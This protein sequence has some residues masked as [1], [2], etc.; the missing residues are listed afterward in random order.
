MKT[1]RYIAFLTLAALTVLT[2]LVWRA[3]NGPT[4]GGVIRDSGERPLVAAPE[5]RGAGDAQKLM[6]AYNSRFQLTLTSSPVI[7]VAPSSFYPKAIPQTPAEFKPP[8]N[9]RSAGPWLTDWNRSPV[10]ANYLAFGYTAL[11]NGRL[12]L[13]GYFYD[14]SKPDTIGAQLISKL[15]FGENSEVGARSVADQFAA[16]ILKLFGGKTLAG[17]KIWFTSK[18]GPNK[19]IWSM[20]WDGTNQKQFTSYQSICTMPTVS[21]DGSKVAFTQLSNRGPLI[22]VHAAESGRRLPFINPDASTNATPEFTP[23]GSR[24]LFSSTLAGGFA[25]LYSANIDGSDLRRITSFRAIEVE[26]KVNPKTGKTVLYVSDRAGAGRPQIWMMSIEGTDQQMISAGDGEAVNPA[27]S[28]DG[29]HL[30]FSWTHGLAP[31]NYNIFVMDVQERKFTQLTF[32][33][34]R[35]ENPTWAPDGIHLAFSS[36]RNGSSQIWTMLADGTEL[37]QLTRDGINEKPV[38]SK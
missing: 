18:R 17:T 32:G 33:A 14:V 37:K 23:D 16:D 30:A 8:V 1:P 31:G 9:G 21:V 36:N 38:W 24:L 12:V 15:Y 7:K 28:P 2:P 22:R 3:Q 10:N 19:E 6:A 29:T 25:N 4:I 5:L 34:G 27:W 26:P 35:N 20:D 11:Q 13:F